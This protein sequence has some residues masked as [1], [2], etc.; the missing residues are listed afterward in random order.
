MANFLGAISLIGGADGA[1][2]K[3]DGTDL[4]D[5]DAAVVVTATKVYI[6][7]LDATSGAAEGSPDVIKPD[8]NAGTKRWILKTEHN[9]VVGL[10]GGTTAEYYH[11]TAAQHTAAIRDATNAQNGLMPTA[12]L[13]GWDAAA[14]HVSN[15]G[16]D[17]SKVTANETATGLNT[18]HRGVVSGNP[19]VVTQAELSLDPT[20]K[21]SFAGASFSKTVHFSSEVDN[22]NS[23]AADTIDWSAGN[24]QKSTLTNDCTFTFSPAPSGPCNLM[25]RLIQDGS[26]GHDVTWPGTVKWLGTEATWT[27]G[28]AG[29]TIIVS[30]YFDGT[31]YWGQASSWEV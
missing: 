28:A 23:G 14:T 13:T 30:F 8:T 2:D 25:F 19:H 6:Y 1:L 29:K 7:S 20:S 15:D 17:H 27:D 21:P 10:Q 22:G 5:L 12:K 16:S 26:G 18:T 3:I 24:K 9:N 11:M 4:A 31:N